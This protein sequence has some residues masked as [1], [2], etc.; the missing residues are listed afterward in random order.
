MGAS[1]TDINPCL[2]FFV[3]WHPTIQ[4][5][6]YLNM[7]G[8]SEYKYI[9]TSATNVLGWAVL[10]WLATICGYRPLGGI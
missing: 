5:K 9:F 1:I 7:V 3:V 2:K 4:S 8:D 6:Q 10:T